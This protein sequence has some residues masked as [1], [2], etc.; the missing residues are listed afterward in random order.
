MDMCS[1]AF[2][3]HLAQS[4]QEGKVSEEDINIACRRILEAKYKLGLFIAPYRYCNTK[5]SK[6]EI[7]TQENR[8]V[9]REVAAETFV[10]LKTREIFCHSRKKERLP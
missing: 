2:V 10:L 5:R 4:L 1:N 6:N 3:K 9:A 7:Y 8:K